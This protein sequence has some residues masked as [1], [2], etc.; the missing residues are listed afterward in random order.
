[1]GLLQTAPTH[2]RVTRRFV[3]DERE[4]R[5]PLGN[6]RKIGRKGLVI[7]QR[8][9]HLVVLQQQPAVCFERRAVSQHERYSR[10]QRQLLPPRAISGIRIFPGRGPEEIVYG[11]RFAYT[12]RLFH[13]PISDWRSIA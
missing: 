11:Y 9:V 10:D 4:A 12:H 5:R 6:G 2:D 7:A 3:L 13:C 8:F 1:M